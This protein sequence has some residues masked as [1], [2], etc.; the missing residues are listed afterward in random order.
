MTRTA[1]SASLIASALLWSAAAQAYPQFQLT[2]GASRCGQCH[3]GPAGGGLLTGY[4]RDALTDDIARAGNGGFLHGLV[5]PPSW[6]LLGGDFRGAAGITRDGSD[7]SP[8]GLLFP[9]QG[10]LYSQ[11]RVGSFSALVTLGMRGT[12]RGQTTQVLDRVGSR[13]HY[14]M[15]RPGTQGVFVR[16]GRFMLPYG[17]RLAEHPS[18]VRR[19][20]GSNLEEEPLGISG[21]FSTSEHDLHVTLFTQAPLRCIGIGCAKAGAGVLYERRVGERSALGAQA[22][23]IIFPAE[24]GYRQ[25]GGGI[26]GKHAFEHMPL[27][28]LAELDY[29]AKVISE[30]GYT[31]HQVVAHL[32][33]SLIPTRGLVLTTT[34]EAFA[35]DLATP[36]ATRSAG[37]F[38]L[39][40][41]PWAHVE[42][43]SYLRITD[44]GNALALAIL[45]YTL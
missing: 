20:G 2:M 29:D 44:R 14:L 39:Q 21:G 25:A 36:G 30:A 42:L 18:Y 12:A 43:I 8:E 4:G 19:F 13:E 23:A 40:F 3:V 5:E 24:I 22:R 15:W 34:A 38:Q 6:L 45:H 26:L 9:M 41:F 37:S 7:A 28:L 1:I 35:A 27:L 17:L 31:N 33:A 16:A 11:F 10:D 32:G